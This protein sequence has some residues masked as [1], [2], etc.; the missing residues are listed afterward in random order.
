VG[1]TLFIAFFTTLTLFYRIKSG[2]L[3]PV[4]ELSSEEKIKHF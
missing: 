2:F 3:E 1:N 4:G